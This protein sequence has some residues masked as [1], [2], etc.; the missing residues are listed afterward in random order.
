MMHTPHWQKILLSHP[1]TWTLIS[2]SNID[3]ISCITGPFVLFSVTGPDKVTWCKV[4][5]TVSS[6]VFSRT[7]FW[8]LPS[9]IRL[10]DGFNSTFWVP[11]FDSHTII[12]S[13][14]PDARH[15][16]F[17]IDSIAS[18]NYVHHLHSLIYAACW[19]HSMKVEAWRRVYGQWKQKQKNDKTPGIHWT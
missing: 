10:W 16:H 15:P 6:I 17:S 5:S 14:E 4:I 11:T 13:Q 8:N 9:F 12:P 1:N 3:E 7:F 18:N 19:N 2:Y